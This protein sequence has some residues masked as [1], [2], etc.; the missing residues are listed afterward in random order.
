MLQETADEGGIICRAA[1]YLNTPLEPTASIVLN[2]PF[3]L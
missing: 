1:A 2:K 3:L